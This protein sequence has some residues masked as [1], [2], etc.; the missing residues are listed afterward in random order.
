MALCS[1][2]FTTQI[3]NLPISAWEGFAQRTKARRAR[4]VALGFTSPEPIA[5]RLYEC[6][7]LSDFA[8]RSGLRQS[9]AALDFECK[10]RPITSKNQHKP[11]RPCLP[12]LQISNS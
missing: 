5:S 9:S 2:E 4:G 8:K 10:A 6:P 11:A 1:P 3:F 12:F 7:N